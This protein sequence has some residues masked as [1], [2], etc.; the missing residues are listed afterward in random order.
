MTS[1]AVEYRPIGFVE[2]SFAE[3]TRPEVVCGVESKLVLETRFASAI[4]ALEVGQHLF[5]VYHMHWPEL[6]RDQHMPEL[7]TRRAAC[8]PN[9]IGVTLTRVVALSGS[10][11]TVAGLDALNGLPILDVKPCQAIWD[12]PPVEPTERAPAVVLTGGPGGGKSTLIE[13]M[14]QDTRLASRFVALPEAVQYVRFVNIS[15]EEKLFQ[16]ALVHLH[17]GLEDGLKRALGRANSRFI[18]CHRG[19]LDPLA[20]WMERGWPEK[21]FFASTC[22]TLDDHYRR[23]VA[24]IHLV[25]SADGVPSAYTRWPRSHRPEEAEEAIRL[26]R[27]LQRIWS[28][29]SNYFRIDNAARDWASKSREAREILARCL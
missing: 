5:V 16:S 19:S 29:H 27:C 9:P 23:Y 21:E 18:V 2:C 8:R 3:P 24:V 22:T 15:P 4:A 12:E 14:R 10:T 20:F 28:G 25:T 7:F 13:E 17:M 1:G 11:I 26:D 6:W